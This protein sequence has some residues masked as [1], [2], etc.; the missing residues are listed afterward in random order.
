MSA[1][2]YSPFTASQVLALVRGAAKEAVAPLLKIPGLAANTDHLQ[3]TQ[4]SEVVAGLVLDSR[5]TVNRLQESLQRVRDSLTLSDRRE[6]EA[7]AALDGAGAPK[8]ALLADRVRDLSVRVDERLGEVRANG[9]E[10]AQRWLTLA[11]RRG[12][13]L[14][15]V[16]RALTLGAAE[17]SDALSRFCAGLVSRV[18]EGLSG[19]EGEAVHVMPPLPWRPASEPPPVAADYMTISLTVPVL[20]DGRPLCGF[21]QHNEEEWRIEDGEGTVTHWL[22]LEAL[23]QA[24][25]SR[26]QPVATPETLGVACGPRLADQFTETARA[27]VAGCFAPLRG[28]ITGGDALED[29]ALVA[30]VVRLLTSRGSQIDTARRLLTEAGVADSDGQVPRPLLSRLRALITERDALRAQLAE[31]QAAAGRVAQ[32]LTRERDAAQDALA[33]ARRVAALDLA[34]RQQLCERIKASD[35]EI[36]SLRYQLR[37]VRP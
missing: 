28:L 33:T 7:H 30:A 1:T 2:Y 3:P 18:E 6:A 8:S 10:T 35:A 31:Q 22:P 23:Q 20:C 12:Q 4:V 21:Y 5:D 15:D 25:E 36:D 9:D 16:R 29:R 32:T 14:R 19:E 11:H 27:Y 26:P 13:V 24:A 37:A 17:Q 34:E